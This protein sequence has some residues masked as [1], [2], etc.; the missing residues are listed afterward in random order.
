M[1]AMTRPSGRAGGVVPERGFGICEL[2][3]FS[4]DAASRLETNHAYT[5]ICNQ[6]FLI[7][8]DLDAPDVRAAPSANGCSRTSQ[9]AGPDGSK[10]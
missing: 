5:A 10:E 8:M 4:T 6:P 2:D 9:Y 1:D 7:V 3:L